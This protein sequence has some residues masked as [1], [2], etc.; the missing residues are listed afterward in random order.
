MLSAGFRSKIDAQTLVFQRLTVQDSGPRGPQ[1]WCHLSPASS[2]RIERSVP[3]ARDRLDRRVLRI[4]NIGNPA[5][6]QPVSL[7]RRV[8]P[9]ATMQP[10]PLR[11]YLVPAFIAIGGAPEAV[12][13]GATTMVL[14][15]TNVVESRRAEVMAN[16]TVVIE[17]RTIKAIGGSELRPP[18]GARVIDAR[19]TYLIPG[20]WDMHVHLATY[21]V[22][23][24]PGAAALADNPDFFF[25][26]FLAHGVTGV[27]DMSGRIELLSR[28]RA[29]TESGVRLGPRIVH[30][31]GKIG[32]WDRPVVPGAPPIKT[33]ADFGRSARMLAEAGASF[34]K[35]DVATLEELQALTRHAKVVGLPVVGH[36]PPTISLTTAVELGMRSVEHLHGA[37]A[38]CSSVESASIATARRE[39]SWWGRLLIR[40]GAWDGPKRFDRRSSE[41]IAAKDHER[42][43]AVA[44]RL[45]AG[46]TWV[47]PTLIGLLA[48]ADLAPTPDAARAR[49]LP[50]A[51]TSR[52]VAS[53]DSAA[54][55]ARF[56]RYLEI[57][58]EFA[59]GGAPFL[60][61]TDA[62]GSGRVPGASLGDELA[63]MVRAGATPRQALYAATEGPA[64]FLG[65]IDSL[66]TVEPGKL[67]DLVLLDRNPLVQIGDIQ[68]VRAVIS[69]GRWYDRADL[70]RLI[71]SAVARV[72]EWNAR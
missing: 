43:L 37:L 46:G 48:G 39:A 13:Q 31:G 72:A 8:Q 53:R 19:G 32:Q 40:A 2:P 70:D 58:G 30:T 71:A 6:P 67:A 9:I 5:S 4:R 35:A 63:L 10:H 24:G 34:L 20:L 17:G 59:R 22:N 62:P 66:G 1:S 33:D 52:H 18:P 64:R 54:A 65:T 44:R 36:L 51:V 23:G 25:P 7:A 38:A 27:R 15:G 55:A 45:A 12:A 41:E 50:R 42:C 69:A 29:E 57:F 3:A 47:V 16:A 11:W 49:L 61:G 26:L 28:W 56:G 14:V 68:S 21:A 60:A